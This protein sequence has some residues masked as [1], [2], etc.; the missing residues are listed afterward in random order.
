MTCKF[1]FGFGVILNHNYKQ[2]AVFPTIS[3]LYA[4]VLQTKL[5]NTLILFKRNAKG[6]YQEGI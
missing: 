6:L 1:L 2:Y 3:L 5:G 4:S